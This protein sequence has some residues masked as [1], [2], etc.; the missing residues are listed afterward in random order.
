VNST[1]A[2]QALWRGLPLRAF[3]QAVYNKPEFV[4]DQ[5]LAEFF[6][7]PQRPDAQAYRDYRRYLLATSQ[8]TGGFY[9]AR[10]RRA[11]LRQVTDRMLAPHDPYDSLRQRT[12]TQQQQL[13]VVE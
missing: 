13:R 10:G 2:Q 7:D 1:A 11:L 3:G 8:V 4:S 6:A 12:A 9:S 5:P